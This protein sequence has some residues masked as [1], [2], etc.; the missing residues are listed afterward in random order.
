MCCTR[1]AAWTSSRLTRACMCQGRSCS[2]RVGIQTQKRAAQGRE[3]ATAVEAD[4]RFVQTEEIEFR[5]AYLRRGRP[6]ALASGRV[7]A[8]C[9]V[10]DHPRRQV[11]VLPPVQRQRV[12][13]QGLG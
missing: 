7:A 3:T 1:R 6:E 4:G 5:D 12:P 9:L 2:V 11:A 13:K 10:Q 8:G